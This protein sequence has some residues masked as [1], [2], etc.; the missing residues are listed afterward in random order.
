MFEPQRRVKR[1]L[2]H[3]TNQRL[4]QVSGWEHLRLAQTRSRYH[5]ETRK[6]SR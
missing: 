2:F 5:E 4:D 1:R 6:R 3:P